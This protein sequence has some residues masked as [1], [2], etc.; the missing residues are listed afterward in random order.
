MKAAEVGATRDRT[1]GQWMRADWK[2]SGE[3]GARSGFAA[4]DRFLQ[5]IWIFTTNEI[6][7][8][9]NENYTINLRANDE[10]IWFERE[11]DCHWMVH[12][13]DRPF[14]IQ[15]NA[16]GPRMFPL[17]ADYWFR[18]LPLFGGDSVHRY[19]NEQSSHGPAY[20]AWKNVVLK[21]EFSCSIEWNVSPVSGTAF[22]YANSASFKFIRK[23][24]EWNFSVLTEITCFVWVWT[25][26]AS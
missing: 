15:M 1:A 20:I 16:D 11:M 26:W 18:I 5:K 24:N 6:S 10:W 22:A 4:N 19:A 12:W 8:G 3:R 23:W 7:L 2:K 17:A 21:K 14:C 9:M 25:R 13:L